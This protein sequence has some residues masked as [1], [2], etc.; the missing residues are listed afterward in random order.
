MTTTNPRKFFLSIPVK[1]LKQSMEF[2]AKLGF[3][4]N[5]RFTDDKAACMVISEEA[6]VMLLAEPYFKT[7]TKREL[8]SS[9][10]QTEALFALSCSSRA[11]VDGLLQKAL[12]AGGKAAMPPVDHGFMYGASF[13]D[14]DDHHWE[15]VWMDPQAV[16]G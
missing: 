6:Y 5:S 1:N 2:F 9:G 3:E 12:A 4:Y 16:T 10:T 8:W 7:F 14:L 13:Y 11:E 15:I